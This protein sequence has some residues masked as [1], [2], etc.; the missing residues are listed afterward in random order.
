MG[1]SKTYT[2]ETMDEIRYIKEELEKVGFVLGST[3]EELNIDQIRYTCTDGHM[4]QVKLQA[5]KLKAK[6]NK[7]CNKCCGSKVGR[8]KGVK[9]DAVDS[10]YA[11]TT[12]YLKDNGYVM[13]SSFDEFNHN[14]DP[15][16]KTFTFTCS[17]NHTCTITLGTYRTRKYRKMELC[18]GCFEE[19]KAQVKLEKKA[20]TVKAKPTYNLGETKYGN[21]KAYLEQTGFTLTS[22]YTDFKENRISFICPQQHERTITAKYMGIRKHSGET[23][24]SE[25][26][27]GSKLNIKLDMLKDMVK[28]HTGHIVL[29]LDHNRKVTFE[30]VTCGSVGTTFV[31][32]M[33]KEDASIYCRSCFNDR[34]NKRT[35]QDV[36][37]ELK[38]L[39]IDHKVDEYHTNKNV[40]FTCS[41]NPNHKF[42]IALHDL[43]RRGCPRCV[44]KAFTFPSGRVDFVVGYEPFALAKLLKTYTEDDIKTTYSRTI[45]TIQYTNVDGRKAKYYPDIMVQDK[46]IIEVKSEYTYNM[47]KANNELKMKATK[48]A[49]YMV[50]LWIINCD[51]TDISINKY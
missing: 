37:E 35:M 6:A 44:Q 20:T 34:V 40:S 49:G 51:G 15:N 25:C 12:T 27:Q 8:R 5:F 18:T 43:K 7:L 1:Q 30:C 14:E 33:L 11:T 42:T 47:A 45:P 36:Q 4:V 24:C 10:A 21:Y 50:E 38:S 31:S 29:G 28:T 48:E 22:T 32:N 2:K 16:K 17:K 19:A 46:L 23:L 26:C 41:K 39:N 9:E 3:D 13:V